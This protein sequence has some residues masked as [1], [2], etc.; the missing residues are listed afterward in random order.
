M[1][2]ENRIM[3]QVSSIFSVFMVFF[4]LGVGIFLIFYTDR[5]TIDKPIR[6][7][8]GSTF[9]FYGIYRAA[10]SYVNIKEAFFSSNDD[11]SDEKNSG[12][13]RDKYRHDGHYK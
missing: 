10:R 1:M 3:Q 7:I 9:V 2:S 8:V 6:V 13:N 4:Y 5:S 11:D 12:F